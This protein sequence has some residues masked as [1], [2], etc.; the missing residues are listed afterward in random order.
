M[1]EGPQ[2]LQRTQKAYFEKRTVNLLYY[3]RLF[4][5]QSIVTEDPDDIIPSADLQECQ[6]IFVAHCTFAKADVFKL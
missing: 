6:E 1:T 4:Y 5:W 3:L 2:L